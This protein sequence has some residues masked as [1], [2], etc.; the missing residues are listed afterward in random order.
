MRTF[1]IRK[2]HQLNGLGSSAL[3]R[4]V[5]PRLQ[6]LAIVLERL[7]TEGKESIGNQELAVR[8]G[9]K[10]K[11]RGLLLRP[12]IGRLHQY[13]YSTHACPRGR[14]DRLNLPHPRIVVAP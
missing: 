11:L 1:K 3:G 8:Q 4:S 9:E 2:L 5:R 10:R 7:G 6:N 12:G 13:Q 14:Q